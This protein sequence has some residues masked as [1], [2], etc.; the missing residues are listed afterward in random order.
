[1]RVN[2]CMHACMCVCMYARVDACM[3]VCDGKRFCPVLFFTSCCFPLLL[4]FLSFNFFLIPVLFFSLFFPLFF[5]LF[6]LVH[7]TK[8]D[9]EDSHFHWYPSKSCM[10]VCMSTPDVCIVEPYFCKL[11][12][13]SRMIRALDIDKS[14]RSIVCIDEPYFCKL[15]TQSR[16]IR[17][18]EIDKSTRS[19]YVYSG[20]MYCMHR[21]N[22]AKWLHSSEWRNNCNGVRKSHLGGIKFH[23]TLLWTSNE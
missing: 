12:T 23:I 20:C 1:M 17:A 9:G 11:Q 16:M 2:L 8:W 10:H 18:L 14:T 7:F 3:Y 4:L 15:Q 22:M 5:V 6:F 19:M 21:R 13:Q